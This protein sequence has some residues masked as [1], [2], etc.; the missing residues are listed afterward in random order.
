MGLTLNLLRCEETE[1]ERH[2]IKFRL[3]FRERHEIEKL[4]RRTSMKRIAVAG[5]FG[6]LGLVAAAFVFSRPTVVT[7]TVQADEGA[8]CSLATAA[9]KYG[10]TLTGTVLL[11]TGPVP[12]AAVGRAILDADGNASGTEARNVGGGYADET[13][14]GTFTVNPDCTG[15][16]MLKFS[17]QSG[18]LVRTSVLAIVFDDSMKEIRFVQRS[19]TL[20]DGTSL[21][22]V[23][24]AD[25]KRISPAGETD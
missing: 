15:A 8:R 22:V 17:D 6:V 12:A 2:A 18:V 13:F 19:L 23:I 25:A 4:A 21:R 11:P 9:G 24:T 14:T 1:G 20:P 16:A 5:I 10:F 7:A 3:P